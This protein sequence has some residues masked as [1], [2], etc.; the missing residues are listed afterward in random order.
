MEC[1]AFSFAANR[2]GFSRQGFGLRL[3]QLG[4]ELRLLE[5]SSV[6]KVRELQSQDRGLGFGI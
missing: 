1:R 4:L 3:L 2:Q 6:A 5:L